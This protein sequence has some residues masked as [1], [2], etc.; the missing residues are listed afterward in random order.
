[1]KNKDIFDNLYV[2]DIANNHFGNLSHAKKIIDQ[3]GNIIKKFKIKAA[4]KF[5]FRNLETF[6]HKDFINSDEKYVRRFL[7]TKLSDENFK[8]LVKKIKKKIFLHLVHLLMSNQL[9]KLKN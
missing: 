4:F 8:V 7:D 6:V 1:M 2:L 9:I 3:F 5:Q